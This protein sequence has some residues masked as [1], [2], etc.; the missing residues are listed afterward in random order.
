M[1]LGKN[2]TGKITTRTKCHKRVNIEQRTKA[3]SADH[4]FLNFFLNI[5]FSLMC[6]ILYEL[7]KRDLYCLSTEQCLV[8]L[9]VLLTF[10]D[11]YT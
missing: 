4:L 3:L 7:A 10:E 5:L 11:W 6:Y 1:P 9:S 8:L 2:A